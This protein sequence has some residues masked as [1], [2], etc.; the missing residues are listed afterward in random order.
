M[1]NQAVSQK[2]KRYFF[3]VLVI[4]SGLAGLSYVLKL[5]ELHPQCRIALL[6]KDQLLESNSRYAQGG[7]ASVTLEDDSFEHHVQDTLKAGAGLCNE[8]VV[9]AIVTRAPEAIAFL[10][11]HGVSFDRNVQT[12]YSLAKE[13]GHSHRRIYH[14]GDETGHHVM[15]TLIARVKTLKNVL[16]FEEHMAVNLIS[17]VEKHTPGAY[18]EVIGAYV[19]SKVDGLIHTFLAECVVLATGGA[20]KVYRYTSNPNV[21]TGD[22]VALAYRAGARVGNLEFYQ[23]HPTLLYHPACNNFLISEALRGEGAYLRTA[24]GERFM[25]RYDAEHMELATRDVIARAIFNELERSDHKCV[26]LD[27]THK[28]KDFLQT[29]FPTIY[30][31]LYA[32]GIDMSV[33]QIPV[34][35]G[36]HYCC[37]GVLTDIAG[38]TDILRLLVIG[39]TAFTG[40]HGANRLASN[41]LLEGIVMGCTAAM[42]TMDILKN[43]LHFK[44]DIQDWNSKSVVDVRRASQINAHWR[45][46]RGEMTS[47]AGIVRTHAGLQVLL[48]LISVRREMIEYYYWHHVLSYDVLELRN[49]LQV[50]EL[51]VRS[52]M[53]RDES[54]GV[55]YREDYPHTREFSEETIFRNSREPRLKSPLY[56]RPAE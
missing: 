48:N 52:A 35:P 39:E 20:G 23:F 19:L 41:S 3:D 49:I 5:S 8:A 54:R 43:K 22:G 33:D 13:G 26:Y 29:R 21:A 50:A 11:T 24:S 47:Y 7:I 45:G 10:E 12:V 31:T 15:E 1:S 34:V 36:A 16:I 53:A 28:S 18:R 55:H 30:Q 51:I 2:G 9:R 32:L 46:L 14:A 17:Q 6:S 44:P 40:L 27:I 37:G 25:Q 56:E 4:G 38:K 42:H